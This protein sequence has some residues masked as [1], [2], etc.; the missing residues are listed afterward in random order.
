MVCTSEK[1]LIIEHRVPNGGV[2]ERTKGA[3]YGT[4]IWNELQRLF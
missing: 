4:E 1:R 3:G 2:T